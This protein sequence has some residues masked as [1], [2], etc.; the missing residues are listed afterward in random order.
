MAV[1]PVFSITRLGMA[2]KGIGVSTSTR[3]YVSAEIES[4]LPLLLSAAIITGAIAPPSK[5]AVY[6]SFHVSSAVAKNS[7]RS[8]NFTLDINGDPRSLHFLDDMITRLSSNVTCAS[9]TGCTSNHKKRTGGTT[10]SNSDS[11]P[12]GNRESVELRGMGTRAYCSTGR[13]MYSVSVG[14]V[15]FTISAVGRRVNMGNTG[16]TTDPRTRTFVSR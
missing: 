16:V 14:G 7:K 15:A 11:D 6:V 1:S 10:S 4:P 2:R 9:T 12:P 13:V 3:M 5:P 8:F